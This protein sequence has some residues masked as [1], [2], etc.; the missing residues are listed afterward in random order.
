MR[1]RDARSLGWSCLATRVYILGHLPTGAAAGEEDEMR[2]MLTTVV[3]EA[4]IVVLL[5]SQK[6]RLSS[7]ALEAFISS[8]E[9]W[10]RLLGVSQSFKGPSMATVFVTAN[11]ATFSLDMRR[12]S[13]VV[14]L[15]LEVERVEDRPFRRHSTRILCW[16]CARRF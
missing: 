14:E 15:H 5:N 16:R 2:K 12:R 8:P 7:A 3:R 13:L 10:D 9:W 4:G 1:W 11:G 6:G